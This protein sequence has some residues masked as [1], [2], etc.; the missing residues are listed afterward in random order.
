MG[1][2]LDHAEQQPSSP[3]ALWFVA[4]KSFLGKIIEVF[5]LGKIIE[6]SS[7][8]KI[9]EVSSLGKIIEVFSFYD[10]SK[11]YGE[12]VKQKIIE[13]SMIFKNHRMFDDFRKSSNV[14]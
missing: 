7:L 1:G 14:R 2:V 13:H 10:F 12:A 3:A 8:G 5:F 4:R 6:V 11:Y 9:I